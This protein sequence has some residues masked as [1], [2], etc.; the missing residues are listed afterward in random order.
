MD[1]D[2]ITKIITVL[3][4]K[5]PHRNSIDRLEVK[6]DDGAEAS[7]LPLDSFR[8]MFPHALDEDSYLQEGFLKGSKTNLHCYDDSRLINLWLQH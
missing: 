2:G 7:I 4:V 3:K 1:P 6:V 8:S 5:L